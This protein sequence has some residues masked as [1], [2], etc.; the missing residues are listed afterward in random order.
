[1]EFKVY[2]SSEQTRRKVLQGI[3]LVL[4]VFGIGSMVRGVGNTDTL[5]SRWDMPTYAYVLTWIVVALLFIALLNLIFSPVGKSTV[6]L[7]NSSIYFKKGMFSDKVEI[8]SDVSEVVRD[9]G[10]W[11]ANSQSGSVW[12][13]KTVT[14]RD[15]QIVVPKE[16]SKVVEA[17]AE[18]FAKSKSDL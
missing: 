14:L 10:S 7:E 16:D 3:V 18:K 1:M 9:Y 4:I 12:T 15:I 8:T 5:Y 13:I 6:S 17:V 2:K 11:S